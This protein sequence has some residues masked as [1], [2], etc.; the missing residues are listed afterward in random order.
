MIREEILKEIERLAD[1][2]SGTYLNQSV[3]NTSGQTMK[4][5]IIE[6]DNE[7]SENSA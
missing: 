5:I 2:L 4:R 7:I 1:E 3:I 6:Y